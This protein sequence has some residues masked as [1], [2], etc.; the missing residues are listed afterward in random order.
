MS[1]DAAITGAAREIPVDMAFRRVFSLNSSSS[2]C[3]SVSSEARFGMLIPP[4]SLSLVLRP[5]SR[6]PAD[7]DTL[8][9]LWAPSILSLLLPLLPAPFEPSA[10]EVD[11]GPSPRPG[12]LM[13]LARARPDAVLDAR[14]ALSGEVS[15]TSRAAIEA[16]TLAIRFSVS[17]RDKDLERTS[18]E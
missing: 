6:G 18:V 17:I 8:L 4:R 5:T 16:R 11:P 3:P 2:A 9:V 10:S 14:L 13:V 7:K 1:E 15:M 12:L